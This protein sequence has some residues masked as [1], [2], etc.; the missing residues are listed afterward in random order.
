MSS[1]REKI[2]ESRRDFL[3]S[4][5]SGLGGI[6]LTTMLAEQGLLAQANAA[7]A[8][9]KRMKSTHF[10]AQAKSCIFLFMAGAPSQIDLFDPKPKL[11]E[12]NGQ[13]MPESML[14]KVRFAFIKKESA[15][16]MGSNAGFRK[17]G[18]SG[19]RIPTI[20]PTSAAA[21]MTSP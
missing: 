8:V 2:F 19:I 3:T 9:R 18:E 14:E 12:L 7:G 5:A 1:L 21:P 15:V 20:F 10:P 17:Y 4:S 13:P 16:L 6:A 11:T